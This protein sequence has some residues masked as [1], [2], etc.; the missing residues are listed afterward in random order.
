MFHGHCLLLVTSGIVLSDSNRNGTRSEF[1][2]QRTWLTAPVGNLL[3]THLETKFLKSQDYSFW[4]FLPD[5]FITSLLRAQ[6]Q[7]Q[8]WSCEPKHER[9]WLVWGKRQMLAGF[10][11]VLR[12]GHIPRGIRHS[13]MY[14]NSCLTKCQSHRFCSGRT[15]SQWEPLWHPFLESSGR[16]KE[17]WAES[18]QKVLSHCPP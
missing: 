8:V 4:V 15:F 1:C 11:L 3:L 9:C 13:G 5:I 16:S 14:S 10:S 7:Y 6:S 2:Y 17:Q 12:G 18:Q